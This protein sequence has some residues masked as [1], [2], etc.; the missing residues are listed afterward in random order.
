MHTKF[1]DSQ[2]FNADNIDVCDR[3]S[4]NMGKGKLYADTKRRAVENNTEVQG[5]R[6]TR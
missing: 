4:E 2:Q 1:P 3:D 6:E 5:P